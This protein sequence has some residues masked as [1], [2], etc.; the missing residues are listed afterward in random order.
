M[1]EGPGEGP[2]AGAI[3]IGSFVVLVGLCLALLGGGCTMMLLGDMHELAA[4]GGWFFLLIALAILAAGVALVRL[5]I[6]LLRGDY[7]N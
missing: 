2:G 4:Y 7:R 3:L 5:G 1:S 6:K